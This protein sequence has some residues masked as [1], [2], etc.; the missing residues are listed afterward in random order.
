MF[1][2]HAAGWKADNWRNSLASKIMGTETNHMTIRFEGLALM[3][4]PIHI[5]WG[6]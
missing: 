4:E 2:I 6:Q 3:E 5:T 1:I